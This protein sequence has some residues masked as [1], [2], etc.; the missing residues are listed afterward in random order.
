MLYPIELG[1]L[2]DKPLIVAETQN[3][4]KGS[5]KLARSGKAASCRF[6]G[7][8]PR[9]QSIGIDGNGSSGSALR[10]R[11]ASATGRIIEG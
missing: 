2:I 6:Y 1:V 9:V 7:R 3:R 8:S 5:L 11:V 4:E 10:A